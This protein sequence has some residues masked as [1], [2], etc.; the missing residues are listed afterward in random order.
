MQTLKIPSINKDKNME[1]R[2]K[3]YIDE[4]FG[5]GKVKGEHKF[6]KLILF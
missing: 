6:I 2:L 1:E 3:R 4:K 5:N